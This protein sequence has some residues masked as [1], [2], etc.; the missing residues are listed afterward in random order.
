VLSTVSHVVSRCLPSV[1]G[2]VKHMKC[3]ARSNRARMPQQPQARQARRSP[4]PRPRMSR[5]RR[6]TSPDRPSDCP[7]RADC[8]SRA[9]PR[10]HV[11]TIRGHG[12]AVDSSCCAG[13]CDLRLEAEP[14]SFRFGYHTGTLETL[15]HLSA[16]IHARQRVYVRRGRAQSARRE[17][18]RLPALTLRCCSRARAATAAGSAWSIDVV[19]IAARGLALK[20]SRWM[21][22]IA[23]TTAWG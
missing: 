6:L 22:P 4:A 11:R 18:S 17:P 10:P 2:S 8:P 16:S 7:R 12:T 5:R 13:N 1:C 23:S 21:I 3:A 9:T 20:Y 19:Q 14:I 15:C